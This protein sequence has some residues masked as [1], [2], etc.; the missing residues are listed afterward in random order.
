MYKHHRL[1]FNYRKIDLYFSQNRPQK[2][3]LN[4]KNFILITAI[5]AA[6]TMP[7]ISYHAQNT[8]IIRQNTNRPTQ[9]K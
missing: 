3:N 8:V 9:E 6:I 4:E 7:G 5:I 1:N 2:N